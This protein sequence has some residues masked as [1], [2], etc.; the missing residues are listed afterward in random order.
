MTKDHIKLIA[1]AAGALVLVLVV[2]GIGY[3]KVS[4]A[5]GHALE[6]EEQLASTKDELG[7]FRKYIDYLPQAKQSLTEA[8]AKLSTA[9]EEEV[10]WIERG[11]R[12]VSP[13][14]IEGTAIL[15][16]SVGYTFGFDLAADK[17][18]L[19]VADKGIQIKLGQTQL[20]GA[21][22]VT[23][24]SAEYPPKVLAVADEAA[25]Q[26][27]LQKVVPALQEKGKVL[28][29]NE[30]ARIIVEKKLIEH[31]RAFF[32]QQKDVKLIPD[33]AVVNNKS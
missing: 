20:I 22:E 11:E 21:P 7:A 24:L 18:D 17:F 16:L 28:A 27:I 9:V 19:V 5:S 30:A 2:A 29:R 4:K 15:K 6:L 23:V 26:E 10:T 33:I 8:S 13:F 3:F 14:K 25:T 32:Q 12:G 1:I 31:L